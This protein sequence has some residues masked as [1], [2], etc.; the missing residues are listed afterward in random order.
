MSH[1]HLKAPGVR[2]AA[3]GVIA[4]M[5]GGT[6]AGD[7]GPDG[8]RFVGFGGPVDLGVSG[9]PID[10]DAGDVNN[11]GI[12]DVLAAS[13][14]GFGTTVRVWL[15]TP[16]GEFV[17]QSSQVGAPA[18]TTAIR[19]GDFDADGNLDLAIADGAGSVAFRWGV[20][21]GSFLAG[22]SSA[23]PIGGGA[24]DVDAGFADGDAAADVFV[25]GAD[26]TLTLIPGSEN[27][28]MGD[29]A[30]VTLGGTPVSIAAGDLDGDG[31]HDVVVGLADA[32]V[33][34]LVRTSGL[35]LELAGSVSG[36]GTPVA[37]AAGDLSD[38]PDRADVAAVTEEGM[39]L[40]WSSTGD[41]G[42][43]PL[44]ETPVGAEPSAVRIADLDEDGDGDIL[45]TDA[46]AFPNGF[47]LRAYVQD[48]DGFAELMPVAEDRRMIAFELADLDGNTSLDL[49]GLVDDG[50]FRL[51][52]TRVNITDIVPPGP[53][54]VAFPPDGQTGLPRPR[55]LV[56]E[57][58][59]AR[60]RWTE[61][62]GFVVTYRVRIADNPEMVDPVVDVE[63]LT[64]VSWSVPLGTLDGAFTWYW[65]VEACTVA[66]VTAAS[67]PVASFSLTCREDLDGNA[68]IGIG[69]VVEILEAWG[70]ACGG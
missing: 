59:T 53:F 16:D 40:A 33:V 26:G 57:G 50:E 39:L 70:Q 23:V 42:L 17:A 43:T 9:P 61:A 15:G 44:L 65:S 35:T 51:V 52:R 62:A 2:F 38:P 6:A 67:P 46:E 7:E 11:D 13:A 36:V 8:P 48:P 49:V 45:A 30:T 1:Q 29:P 4:V 3:A 68:E 21:D 37:V 18:D 58:A 19:L 54:D 66:G 41:F 31:D 22:G 34:R 25:A 55:D 47:R 12:V 63:G 27:R 32:G 24:V 64:D 56:W 14:S 28:S 69:D 20:G 60:L 5:L 10:V